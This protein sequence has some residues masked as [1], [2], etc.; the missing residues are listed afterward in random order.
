MEQEDLNY[1]QGIM[2][3]LIKR[4]CAQPFMQ[5]M[6]PDD[7]DAPNYYI[8]IRRPMDLGTIQGK[9][10]TNKYK[11]FSDWEKD[12]NL[13]WTNA[14]RF[15]G[16]NHNI[17]CMGQELKKYYNKILDKE[18]PQTMREWVTEVANLQKKLD[19]IV[20]QAPQELSKYWKKEIKLK[21]LPPMKINQIRSLVSAS[22]LLSEK[23]DA[24]AMFGIINN[25]NPE[26][27]AF[28]EDVTLDLDSLSTKT[29]WMLRWYIERRLEEDGL[30]YPNN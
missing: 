14:E 30:R 6:S 5:P 4:P 2:D 28:S 16:K 1:V 11:S 13:I 12:L 21:P 26:V 20:K 10:L 27:Q 8:K 17:T 29:H 9:I 19:S 15:Y 7:E 25:L 24:R 23:E 22:A 18:L 3:D